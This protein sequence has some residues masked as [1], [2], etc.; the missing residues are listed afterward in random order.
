M[1]VA[2]YSDRKRDIFCATGINDDH[3][4]SENGKLAAFASGRPV[5][6]QYAE[7]AEGSN[8]PLPRTFR[9]YCAQSEKTATS[10]NCKKITQPSGAAT[11]RDSDAHKRIAAP[12]ALCVFREHPWPRP[13]SDKARRSGTRPGDVRKRAVRVEGSDSGPVR[14]APVSPCKPLCAIFLREPSVCPLSL[15][16]ANVGR[17]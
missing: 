14:R 16:K 13:K 7:H 3:P 10:P 15:V 1:G 17:L 4:T 5:F 6:Q 11:P 8:T 2:I 9:K 12:K